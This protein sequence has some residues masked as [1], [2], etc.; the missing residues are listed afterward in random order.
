VIKIKSAEGQELMRQGGKILANILVELRSRSV[1]GV[2]GKEIDALANRL[3]LKYKVKPSFKNYGGFPGSVCISLNDAVVHGIPNENPFKKGD[4]ITLD[5]G[6]FYKGFHTDSAVTFV[7]GS[8]GGDDD[9]LLTTR[10]K[11]NTQDL[12]KNCEQ[13]LYSG[14]DL[15]KNGVHLG[16]ISAKIQQIAEA[17]GYGVIR[18]LV[19]HGIGHE[20]HEDPH[21][22]NFGTPGTGPI[23]KTGMTLAIEPM[24]IE[25]GSVDVVLDDDGWTYRSKTGARTVHC[26]HTVLVTDGGYEIL[27][28]L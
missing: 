10:E 11:K 17:A 25:D 1:P 5:I 12:I 16:D 3:C 22:P 13:S 18:M 26:E 8:F 27:T 7:C 23:L 6:V 4:L 9:S 21:I 14:I 15:I 24:F 19:G 2:T 28:R 20:V